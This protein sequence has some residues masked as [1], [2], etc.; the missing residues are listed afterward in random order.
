MAIPPVRSFIPGFA[1]LGHRLG[2]SPQPA[3]DL[4]L[5]PAQNPARRPARAALLAAGLALPL[6][7]AVSAQD[8][9][10]TA[11]D[12][13]VSAQDTA[14]PSGHIAIELNAADSVQGGCRVSFVIHNHHATDIARAVYEAVLFDASGKV[15]R[16]T[17][18]DFGALPSGRPRVRQFVL[19]GAGCEALGRVLI[20][21][22]QTCEM[23]ASTAAPAGGTGNT[24]ACTKGLKLTSRSA[25]E[26]LG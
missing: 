8:T 21:G 23:D 6:A 15:D 19:P 5:N 25:L 10:A 22:A 12:T 14:A 13:A 24:A 2:A 9:A 20:N 3:G 11:Q 1:A 18:F 16:L 26:I 17:L 7:T 4:A